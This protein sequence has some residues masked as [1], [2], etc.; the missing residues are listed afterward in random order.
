MEV[1][2]LGSNKKKRPKKS[3]GKDLNKIEAKFAE[4]KQENE[5]FE[6]KATKML[7]C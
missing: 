5:Q 2:Y 7:K 4:R 3:S 1:L 6:N